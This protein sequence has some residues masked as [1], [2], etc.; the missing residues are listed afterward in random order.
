MIGHAHGAGRLL[1]CVEDTKSIGQSLV[2][3]GVPVGRFSAAIVE[4]TVG[5]QV[6]TCRLIQP[7]CDACHAIRNF[8]QLKIVLHTRSHLMGK[9]AEFLSLPFT[10]AQRRLLIGNAKT[11][12]LSISGKKPALKA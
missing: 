4:M 10:I 6:M 8:C 2:V 12:I 1:C 5:R 3:A 7:G 9:K 11:T